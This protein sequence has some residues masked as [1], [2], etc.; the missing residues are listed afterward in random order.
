[1]HNRLLADSAAG[2]FFQACLPAALDLQP[3]QPNASSMGQ[4]AREPKLQG[5]CPC[6]QEAARL[7][8]NAIA[9]GPPQLCLWKQMR[10]L[11]QHVECPA[12]RHWLSEIVTALSHTV[13]EEAE[14]WG[15][16]T[17]HKSAEAEVTSVP[18]GACKR[19]RVDPHVK[20]WA[21]RSA[22]NGQQPTVAASARALEKTL[23][24]NKLIASEMAAYQATLRLTWSKP[25]TL[26]FRTWIPVRN[27]VRVH[28]IF[29]L[30]TFEHLNKGF[31]WHLM[32]PVLA[33]RAW[34]ST[35]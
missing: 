12:I 11:Y 20:Q 10:Q 34:N 23:Q 15:D 21:L 35:S 29:L 22:A 18:G 32:R 27:I 24:A 3:L 26:L 13:E 1:M 25:A 19:R 7:A 16:L 30:G 4:C 33:S 14:R 17:W 8:S 9:D 31:P 2:H 5:K 6:F 28:L